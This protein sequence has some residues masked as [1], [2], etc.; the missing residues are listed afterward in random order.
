MSSVPTSRSATQKSVGAGQ[1]QRRGG[2]L[3]VAAASAFCY[4]GVKLGLVYAPP[5]KYAALRTSL[6]GGALLALLAACGWPLAPPRRLWPWTIALAVVGTFI[7]YGAMFMSPAHGGTALA[8]VLGNTGPVLLVLLGAVVLHEPL[9]RLRLF[10][11]AL[12]MSGVTLI[13]LSNGQYPTQQSLHATAIPLLGALAGAVGSVLAKRA[14]LEGAVLQVAAWQLLLGAVPL[15]GLSWLIEGDKAVAWS[16]VFVGTLL[17]LAVV[18]TALP[19]ALWYWLLQR[20][21]LGR[22][23]PTLFLVP[24]FGLGLGMIAFQ[25]RL[26]WTQATGLL[27]ILAAL[28]LLSRENAHDG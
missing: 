16:P 24:V 6:G 5:F 25:E 4:T 14:T 18:G 2:I 12:G 19:T 21:D 23:S 9:T 28:V 1:W 20:E 8:S 3:L 13:V 26:S 10:A 7:A 27:P 22:L 17:L 15:F 11:L